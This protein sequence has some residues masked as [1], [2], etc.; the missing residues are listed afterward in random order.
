MFCGDSRHS[1]DSKNR[2]FLPKRFQQGLPMDEEGN[3]VAILTRGLDGCLFLFPESGL[4]KALERLDTEAF[5]GL[6]DRRSQRAFFKYT[7]R[8]TLDSS[9]RFLL[10]E[11]FCDLAGIDREVVM[12]GVR[13]RIEIWSPQR[14]E[15]LDDENEK[16]FEEFANAL[17]RMS[18]PASGPAA[19]GSE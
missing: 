15:A 3:R 5:A 12:A 8:V 17:T 2:V 9:G 7:N 6:D 18:P 13:D 11:K 4:V 10:P 19:G 1:V 14:W 16:A